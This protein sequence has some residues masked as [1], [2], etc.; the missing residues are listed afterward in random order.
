MKKDLAEV[1]ALPAN[2][3]VTWE[4]IKTSQDLPALIGIK[5]EIDE[6]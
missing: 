6:N 5:Y 2:T 4:I 1:D 3:L